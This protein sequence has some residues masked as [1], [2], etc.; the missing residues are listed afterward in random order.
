[1]G[2]DPPLPT[3]HRDQERRRGSRAQTRMR[4]PAGELGAKERR[5]GSRAQ[6][7]RAP[8]CEPGAGQEHQRGSWVLR[9][10][11]H[12]RGSWVLRS[13][14]EGAGRSATDA[15]A[16]LFEA[17]RG[18]ERLRWGLLSRKVQ[19]PGLSS[20]KAGWP[21]SDYSPPCAT[22]TEAPGGHPRSSADALGVHA[23]SL[24]RRVHR[25]STRSSQLAAMNWPPAW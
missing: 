5:R 18:G 12:Q 13:A 7:K 9:S 4:A 22:S 11:E 21:P 20:R 3:G 17:A 19:W 14:G 1:M 2:W 8:A 15:A 10:A 23:V 16:R 24:T 6:T 25:T